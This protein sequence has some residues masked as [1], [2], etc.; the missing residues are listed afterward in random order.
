MMKS[1]LLILVLLFSFSCVITF[2][3]SSPQP[4]QP[5][6][7]VNFYTY[8]AIP[9]RVQGI[10]QDKYGYIW[11]G[12]TDGLY[13]FD[14]I[15][16]KRYVHNEYNVNSICA[17]NCYPMLVDSQG[18]MWIRTSSGLSVMN[19]SINTF[20]NYYL[21]DS[22][23]NDIISGVL[24]DNKH[25]IWICSMGRK[26]LTKY[27]P[28]TNKFT[29]FMFSDSV[30]SK[31]CRTF[32]I[33]YDHDKI[34]YTASDAGVVPF[35]TTT[36]KYENSLPGAYPGYGEKL[37]NWGTQCVLNSKDGKLY[38][39]Y[40]NNPKDVLVVGIYGKQ[41]KFVS[42]ETP[43]VEP[44]YYN[45]GTLAEK[46]DNELWIGTSL[47]A[48]FVYNK[49]TNTCVLCK[50]N[51]DDPKSFPLEPNSLTSSIFKD[52]AGCTW[53]NADNKLVKADDMDQTVKRYRIIQT[54]DVKD[55]YTITINTVVKDWNK[56]KLLIGTWS[57]YGFYKADESTKVLENSRVYACKKNSFNAMIEIIKG[58]DGNRWAVN[59]NEL[60]RYDTIKKTFVPFETDKPFPSN[61]TDYFSFN[62]LIEDS[63]GHLLMGTFRHG[64]YD[65]N[66]K[67]NTCVNYPETLYNPKHAG[68]DMMHPCFEDSDGNIWL[69][70]FDGTYL[71]NLRNKSFTRV[72]YKPGDKKYN[73]GRDLLKDKHGNI[74][75][76]S[77]HNGFR[78][79]NPV[80]KKFELVM[81]N[82]DTRQIR[83]S[84]MQED[85][86]GYI[87]INTEEE[88]CRFDP[89][90]NTFLFPKQTMGIDMGLSIAGFCKEDGTL[91]TS[92]G[93]LLYETNTNRFDG[94]LNVPNIVFNSFKIFNRDT[95]F[96]ENLNDIKTITL[97]YDKNFISVEFAALNFSH[98][99]Y[100][101]YA[102]RMDG[103]DLDW[104]MSGNKNSASYSNLAPGAY[105]LH[106]KGSNNTGLWNQT[107]ATLTIIITPPWWQTW[108]ARLC[109]GAAVALLLV[110]GIKLY[111]ARKLHIQKT[112]F[113]KQQAL[114]AERSRISRDLHDDIGAGLTGISMLSEQLQHLSEPERIQKN[115][116]KIRES[117]SQLV[118]V[119]SEIVWSMNSKNDNLEN[120][121]GFI[122]NYVLN[123]F[124]GL[125][126]KLSM[127]YPD[128]IPDVE[129][130]SKERRNVFLVVKETLNN[131]VKHAQATEVV[132]HVDINA[133][134]MKIK[135]T[136]NGKGFEISQVRRFG[137]GLKNMQSRMNEI[138]GS[139]DI[140]TEGGKGTITDIF[141]YCK[142]SG[143]DA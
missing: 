27:E 133:N 86:R 76:T 45:T 28:T 10:V 129:I 12:S 4:W 126:V 66:P 36:E 24:E 111:T 17:N 26:N 8:P 97:P 59:V 68:S 15:N 7:E 25:N 92:N 67:D 11:L 138:G 5:E 102:Y 83:M 118:D 94:N 53:I 62:S 38:T 116:S 49:K 93:A 143:E 121:L 6:N 135:I 79:Y 122:R 139:F 124:E 100:N 141:I 110:A 52:K 72:D 32:G 131:I 74:W 56:N 91:Y 50:H 41:N 22:L 29:S 82:I 2:A 40:W 142:I 13:R 37:F 71:F 128:V 31:G 81:T 105:V 63:R 73:D 54:N 43:S 101:Q 16:Y 34:I 140:R 90:R 117:S 78:K 9:H 130:K 64:L 21:S 104:V 77:E 108:W 48:L 119:M 75:K 123:Y 44:K 127:E 88:I 99:E 51:V 61:I 109:M 85:N 46:S 114:D 18:L 95:V 98:S 89:L 113:E 132:L 84:D 96:A 33:T 137:N 19:T 136:D 103:V 106:V 112:E 20:R 58:N 14:G 69:V 120:L 42:G 57:G 47:G 65:F 23:F 107:G 60:L 70:S 39:G 35:N 1:K 30:Y 115:A 134:G 87:W 3:Q 55:E 125:P 80:S